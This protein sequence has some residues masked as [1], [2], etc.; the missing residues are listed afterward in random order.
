MKKPEPLKTFRPQ[1]FF[2]NVKTQ[3]KPAPK[4]P[5]VVKPFKSRVP[6]DVTIPRTCFVRD[7]RAMTKGRPTFSDCDSHIIK[8]T[9]A[10]QKLTTRQKSAL[11]HSL[12]V[13]ALHHIGE[14]IY[15]PAR[16]FDSD[17]YIQGLAKEA[18]KNLQSVPAKHAEYKKTFSIRKSTM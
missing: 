15:A 8:P 10:G 3:E 13:N 17:S 16:N 18:E 4:T 6:Y 1:Q 14:E 7:P 9:K 11:A 5:P 2:R 12:A